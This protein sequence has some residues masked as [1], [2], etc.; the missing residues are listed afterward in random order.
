MIPRIH[1]TFEA[2]PAS[3]ASGPEVVPPRTR[4]VT[5]SPATNDTA[6]TPDPHNRRTPMRLPGARLRMRAPTTP[7]MPNATM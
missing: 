5:T 4:A 1:P 6:V 3:A 7:N 2:M